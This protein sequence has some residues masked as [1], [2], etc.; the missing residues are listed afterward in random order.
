[1]RAGLAVLMLLAAA[2]GRRGSADRPTDSTVVFS[3]IPA[4]DAPVLRVSVMR[5]GQISAGGLPV[6]PRVLD[7][8][9]GSLKTA[10]GVVWYYREAPQGRPTIQQQAAISVVLNLM[11]H[12]QLPVRLSTM[13][14]FSDVIARDRAGPPP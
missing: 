10:N 9:F 3:M 4:A 5:D 1:M 12:H 13:P 8:L 2:C 6:A 7:S 14:D 11:I